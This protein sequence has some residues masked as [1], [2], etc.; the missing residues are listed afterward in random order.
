MVSE[1]FR[2]LGPCGLALLA[3]LAIAGCAPQATTEARPLSG[4]VSFAIFTSPG[5]EVRTVSYAISG[6]GI[7]PRTGIIDVGGAGATVSVLV[8]G[9]PA[10][11]GY[12]VELAATSTDGN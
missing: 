11:A 9:I 10:G 12:R 3:G 5:V 2:R 1:R 4:T 8:S 6:N 7:L